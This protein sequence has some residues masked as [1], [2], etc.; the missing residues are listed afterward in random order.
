MV[1]GRARGGEVEAGRE[2]EARWRRERVLW[3]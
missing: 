1:A 2:R 3:A